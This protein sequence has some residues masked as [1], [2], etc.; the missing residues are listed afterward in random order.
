MFTNQIYCNGKKLYH[1][2]NFDHRSYTFLSYDVLYFRV[3]G[4]TNTHILL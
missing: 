3:P 4:M 1:Q 2:R